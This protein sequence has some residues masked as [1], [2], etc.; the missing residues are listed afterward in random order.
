[1][2]RFTRLTL[3]AAAL[4]AMTTLFA[5]AQETAPATSDTAPTTEQAAEPASGEA[6]AQVL[7][8]TCPVM[9]SNP[10]NPDISVEYQGKTV[11]FCCPGCPSTFLANP[12]QYLANLPQF[13][14]ETGE[15]TAPAEPQAQSN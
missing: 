10:V 15:D 13:A 12:E 7:N 9:A 2:S 4:A 3:T 6:S 11:L 14:E 5:A 1:M 8:E